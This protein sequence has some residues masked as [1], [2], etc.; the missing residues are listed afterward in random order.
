MDLIKE[1]AGIDPQKASR[2]ELEEKAIELGEEKENVQKLSLGNLL[3]FI[4]KKT[5]RKKLINPTFVM[6]YPAE[7]KPLAIQ[8]ADG[9]AEMTQL[10]VAGAEITNQ[11]AELVDPIVQRKLLEVQAQAKLDGDAEAM[12]M[13]T[14][15]TTA[16]E[17]GMPPMTG[18]GIGIDRWVSVLTEQS[19][20]RDVIFFPIMKPEKQVLS[21][22]E[23]E[24]K[25]REKKIVVIANEELGYGV[26]ANAIGQLG[27][28]IGM[29]SDQK[30]TQTKFLEDK[31]GRKHYVDALYGMANLAGSEKDLKDFVM[32]CHKAGIQVFDFSDIMRKAHTDEEMV[33]GYK[34]LGTEEIN[35]IAVGAVV[36]KDFEKEFLDSLK[37]FGDSK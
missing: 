15:F 14:D 13:N 6:R 27:I 9:T 4:Y 36:P 37:L 28:E 29:F 24:K 21:K 31:D 7:M 30:L 26:T 34:K 3:D 19:N 16:M 20:I 2:E 5:A 25:Y 18:T 22:K 23:A 33:K 11:Y 32:K 10:V 8:N 1:H 17:Y 35:Y 12:D